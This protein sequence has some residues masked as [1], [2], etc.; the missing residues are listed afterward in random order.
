MNQLSDTVLS[1]LKAS[2]ERLSKQRQQSS[3]QD[4]AANHGSVQPKRLES[5]PSSPKSSPAALQAAD[6]QSKI[7]KLTPDLGEQ[8]NTN[9]NKQPE[10]TR[11]EVTP[12]QL[13][14]D[15]E[16]TSAE[17]PHVYGV[18]RRPGSRNL[19]T[20]PPSKTKLQEGFRNMY[21]STTSKSPAI[22]PTG[23]RK[24]EFQGQADDFR[25][26]LEPGRTPGHYGRR[27]LTHPVANTMRLQRRRAYDS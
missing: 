10:A 19:A 23:V 5:T 14:F 8:T 27:S 1:K 15:A 7:I 2:S 12:T 13:N 17:S 11:P 4:K 22:T 21:T 20:D 3:S 25:R 18:D 16:A 9:K 24:Y 6:V 26:A